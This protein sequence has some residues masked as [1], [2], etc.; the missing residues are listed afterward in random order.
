[1]TRPLLRLA[2]ALLLA[3]LVLLSVTVVLGG[4]LP[5]G[6][7]IA[8]NGRIGSVNGLHLLDVERRFV[9][10]LVRGPIDEFA[11]SPD[12]ERIAYTV[13]PGIT[14]GVTLLDVR[15]GLRRSLL[16][17]PQAEQPIAIQLSW[18]PDGGRVVYTDS[19][20]NLLSVR[21]V[22]VASGERVVLA[23]DDLNT[24][25]AD[26]AWGGRFSPDGR[27]IAYLSDRDGLRGLYDVY[28]RDAASGSIERLTIESWVYGDLR[29]SPDGATLLYVSSRGG[30][31]DIYALDL[32]SAET[33]NLS[34]H[35][36]DDDQ[37]AWSPDGQWIA[38]RS[39]RAGDEDLYLLAPFAD[40][41]AGSTQRL[42]HHPAV[43]CCAEWSP[44]GRVL[45]FLSARGPGTLGLYLMDAPG[46]GDLTPAQRLLDETGL[47]V[48]GYAWRPD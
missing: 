5:R 6:P 27:L 15:P 16:G 13:V 41:P 30:T 18:S 36:A 9:V 25:S 2:L 11:W 28:I 19:G 20:T 29:W 31:D 48:F 45:A 7:Q 35:I 34:E 17:D 3:N 39:R 4:L 47:F 32:I 23:R 22:D 38:F 42:T 33:R 40:D 14:A 1:M 46:A 26:N 37:P 44:D 43:D 10:T 12:G 8:F 21:S 24:P